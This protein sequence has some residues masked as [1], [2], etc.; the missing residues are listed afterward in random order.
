MAN[1]RTVVEKIHRLESEIIPKFYKNV[2]LAIFSRGAIQVGD[3]GKTWIL[4]ELEFEGVA[5]DDLT[6][7]PFALLKETFRLYF[8]CDDSQCVECCSPQIISAAA[9]IQGAD[10][11]IEI[12]FTP[13]EPSPSNG[14]R[15]SYRPIGGGAYRVANV[16]ASPAVIVDENDPPGTSYEGYITGDCGGNQFGAQVPF[17]APNE[18]APSESPDISASASASA[19]ASEPPPPDPEGTIIINVNSGITLN[20]LSGIT[21]DVGM[22]ISGGSDSGTWTGFTGGAMA[23]NVDSPGGGSW[24]VAY[25]GVF[26]ASTTFPAGS[27]VASPIA[28]LAA[29]PNGT[30]IEISVSI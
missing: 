5:D 23:I 13:C 19:S 2:L 7:K 15:I 24:Q 14:Y 16:L 18:D 9:T 11:H 20:F 26:Q 10:N 8:G 29:P 4:S 17:T 12:E 30:T 1:F 6:W 22:P 27:G 28:G 21:H 25:N 3:D